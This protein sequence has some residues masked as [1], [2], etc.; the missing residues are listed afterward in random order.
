MRDGARSKPGD[1]LSA[2]ELHERRHAI[3][4]KEQLTELNALAFWRASAER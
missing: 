4:N 1:L 3:L 2:A